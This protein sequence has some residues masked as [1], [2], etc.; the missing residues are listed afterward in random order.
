MSTFSIIKQTGLGKSDL[1]P[2]SQASLY[3][4]WLKPPLVRS[5][6]AG[7]ALELSGE[8]LPLKRCFYKT[9]DFNETLSSI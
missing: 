8:A 4:Y 9:I 6:S 7:I 1:N 2:E 5:P 3:I